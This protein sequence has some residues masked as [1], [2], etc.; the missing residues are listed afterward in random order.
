M[1][2]CVCSMHEENACI[3]WNILHPKG[4]LGFLLRYLLMSVQNLSNI[5]R[6]V[7]TSGRMT[8]YKSHRN[9]LSTPSLKTRFNRP[10]NR[11]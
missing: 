7:H 10:E 4:G 6:P 11:A 1:L 5:Q 9:Q 8:L 2:L 3:D